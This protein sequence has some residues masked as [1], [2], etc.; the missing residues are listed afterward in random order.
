MKI[1][2]IEVDNHA[3]KKHFGATIYPNLALCKISAYHKAHE[4][5][6]WQKYM[7]NWTNKKMIFEK[8][9]FADFEPRKGFFCKTYL[10]QYGLLNK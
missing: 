3:G 8:I 7:A 9:D 2:L 4:I 5:P 6:Q 1:G 10:E